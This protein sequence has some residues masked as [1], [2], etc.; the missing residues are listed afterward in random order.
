MKNFQKKNF[1][2][3]SKKKIQKQKRKVNH[4]RGNEHPKAHVVRKKS[5]HF[6][7]NASN[8]LMRIQDWKDYKLS[9]HK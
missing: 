6:D 4:K 5:L 3:H 1:H 8:A 7:E 9:N 2:F